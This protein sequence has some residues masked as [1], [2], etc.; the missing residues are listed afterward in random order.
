MSPSA[1]LTMK[2][3]A[4]ARNAP[5]STAS[6]AGVEMRR[7][8]QAPRAAT[9]AGA[10]RGRGADIGRGHVIHS[11]RVRQPG[12]RAWLSWYP[13]LPGNSLVRRAY[14]GHGDP[15]RA[16]QPSPTVQAARQR[17]RP[18]RPQPARRTELASFLRSRRER[19]TPED[20]G[21]ATSGR[22]RTP[23]L[24]REEVAQLAG[25]GVT[26]YT[27]LEQGRDIAPSPR[28]WTRSRRT[29]RLDRARAHPPV[30][31][32]RRRPDPSSPDCSR[33]CPTR[34]SCCSTGWSP[35]RPRW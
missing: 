26:W 25:V 14:W 3:S 6:R 12:T 32:G 31:A 35:T 7:C 11:R 8:P 30:P 24:R 20:V 5:T 21:L 34:S 10:G 19:I 18:A 16:D 2:K 27:W 23:G 22:R 17:Q 29:L 13:A 4:I 33:R 28:C 15:R 1:T 9:G